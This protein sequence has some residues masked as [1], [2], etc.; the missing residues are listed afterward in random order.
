MLDIM[1]QVIGWILGAFWIWM[2]ID[3][4]R[5]EED[6]DERTSW[7]IVLMILNIFIAPIYYF[8]AYR[9]RNRK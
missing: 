4:V 9:P 6:K 5:N 3:C 8:R 7:F 2:L 1:P